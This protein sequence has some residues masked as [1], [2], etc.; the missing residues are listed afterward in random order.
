MDIEF[1]FDQQLILAS[2][3]DGSGIVETGKQSISSLGLTPGVTKTFYIGAEANESTNAPLTF[4]AE[5]SGTSGVWSGAVES[6]IDVTPFALTFSPTEGIT[7]LGNGQN[8][9]VV[10]TDIGTLPSDLEVVIR[11]DDPDIAT[12]EGGSQYATLTSA[13]E[14][15]VFIGSESGGATNISWGVVASDGGGGALAVLA[16]GAEAEVEPNVPF[17][18]REIALDV[19]PVTDWLDD[20]FGAEIDIPGDATDAGVDFFE[21]LLIDN[22]QNGIDA[23]RLELPDD[24]EA[25]LLADK[26][27]LGL[28]TPAGQ[29][30]V[31]NKATSIWNYVVDGFT[32]A[33]YTDF[34]ELGD[35][36]FTDIGNAPAFAGSTGPQGF[37]SWSL[38][39]DTALVDLEFSQLFKD[40]PP[41]APPGTG[42]IPTEFTEFKA[43]ADAAGIFES[44]LD[45]NNLRDIG[46]S[47][48]SQI[49]TDTTFNIN[50]SARLNEDFDGIDRIG[51]D[52]NIGLFNWDGVRVNLGANI[53]YDGDTSGGGSLQVIFD[54]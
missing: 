34:S 24:P 7:A 47:L 19:K 51:G 26:I 28:S 22:L 18:L 45:I 33:D 1:F 20:T 14:E 50:A 38:E 5:V 8:Y 36:L 42:P 3:A 43:R 35:N 11:I 13:F 37:G 21:D 15:L 41:G 40:P 53:E 29:Q 27:E 17:F 52:L 2:N 46:L 30:S 9:F 48:Q 44:I 54:F 6:E 25:L 4:R 16:A 32:E 10:E 31:K 49:G 12:F 23:L 39:I